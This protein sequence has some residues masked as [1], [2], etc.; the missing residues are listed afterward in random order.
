MVYRDLSLFSESKI[1]AGPPEDIKIPSVGDRA[2]SVMFD[3]AIF[4]PLISLLL[5]PL[6]APAVSQYQLG[7][8]VLPI[9]A[10]SFTGFCLWILIQT[11]SF[12]YGSATLGQRI[13]K[14]KVI[15]YPALHSRLSFN[16]CLYR[17]FS[18]S[19]SILFLGIPFFEILTHG[20]RRSLVD[21]AS[22][23]LVTTLKS[24]GDP[25]PVPLEARYLTSLARLVFGMAILGLIANV[26]SSFSMISLKPE[27]T[28][29]L[30]AGDLATAYLHYSEGNASVQ[31]CFVDRV[32]NLVWQEG[33]PVE[34]YVWHYFKSTLPES[35]EK[36]G[37]LICEQSLYECELLKALKDEDFKMPPYVTNKAYVFVTLAE[38]YF[39]KQEYSQALN[40]L[41]RPYTDQQLRVNDQD[42]VIEERMV[43]YVVSYLMQSKEGRAPA[44]QKDPEQKWLKEFRDRYD[45]P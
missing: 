17:S 32:Q 36:Y 39:K 5:S 45:I 19:C 1:L 2:L 27:M 29:N 33:A 21:R 28:A 8:S 10:V 4:I 20:K 25:G 43:K 9:L 23:T 18:W 30:C 38:H 12:Y 31:K 13:F 37:A 34:A 42:S 26:Q 44:S 3:Y 7:I 41:Q 11:L 14:I 24:E 16:Q 6:L 40:Y 15:S 22:D 35:R